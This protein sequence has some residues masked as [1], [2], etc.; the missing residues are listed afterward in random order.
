MNLVCTLAP[1]INT[2]RLVDHIL[3][4]VMQ[5][6]IAPIFDTIK[7]SLLGNFVHPVSQRPDREVVGIGFSS[8]Q[9]VLVF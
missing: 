5:C 2:A 4:G 8:I 7:R 6:E 1:Q 9:R 3:L